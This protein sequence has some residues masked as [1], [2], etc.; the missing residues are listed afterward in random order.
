MMKSR[1]QSLSKKQIDLLIIE[2]LRPNDEDVAFVKE[3]RFWTAEVPVLLVCNEYL[4]T[5][6]DKFPKEGR[7]HFFDCRLGESKFLGMAR[8]MMKTKHIGAQVHKRY[9]TNEKALIEMIKD[10]KQIGSDMYNLSRSG[11][12]FEFDHKDNFKFNTGDV[13]RMTVSL[14]TVQRSHDLS[15]KIMWTTQR[16]RYSGRQG[17][18]LKFIKGDEVYKQ[19]LSNLG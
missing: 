4:E 18:G 11:A 8:K 16:G 12:Y 6:A 9:L 5:D 7:P 13:V 3:V 17:V 2:T 19:L 1:Y 10:G 14:D 15:A